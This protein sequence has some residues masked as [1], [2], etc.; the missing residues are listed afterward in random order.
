MMFKRPIAKYRVLQSMVGDPEFLLGTVVE[1]A[2]RV[3]DGYCASGVLERVADD[4][5]LGSETP[6]AMT[7]CLRCGTSFLA[8][9]APGAWVN[10]FRCTYSWF[11]PLEGGGGD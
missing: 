2:Q 7:T 9:R 4:A 8:S 1:L 3:G 10:C 11:N 6:T 5:A